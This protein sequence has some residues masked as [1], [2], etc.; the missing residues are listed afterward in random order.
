MNQMLLNSPEAEI[1][2]PSRFIEQLGITKVF[3]KDLSDCS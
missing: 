1:S 3:T 2:S